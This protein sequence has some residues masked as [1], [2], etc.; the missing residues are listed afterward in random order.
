VSARD[1]YEVLGV[2]KTA[3]EDE[4]RTQ[5]RKLALKYH[6]DKN[7]GDKQAEER[8]KELAQAY[9]VLS[10]P[11]KRRAYDTRGTR[12]GPEPAQGAGGWEGPEI[13]IE[14]IL[15]RYGD[16]FGGFGERFH[17]GRPAQRRGEDALA[18]ITVDFRTAALGGSVA[19]AL[20]GPVA[21]D[22]CGGSG[23]RAG[24]SRD[25]PECGGSGRVSRATG[26][27]GDMFT[28]T[29]ACPRCEGT[30]L[31]PASRCP[32][33]GGAGA[34]EREREVTVRVPEGTADGSTLRLRGMGSAGMRGGP[35]GD[36]LLEVR[37][38]KDPHWR[39][40]GNDVH[41]PLPVPAPL[42]V[43]GG[44]V[45]ARTLRGEG[46]VTIPA[47]TSSGTVLRLKG[48]GILGGDHLAHVELTVP[49]RPTPEQLDLYRRLSQ[50][51]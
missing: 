30:G 33:C 43:V 3:T 19:I 18:A 39:R 28:V 7:P 11:E 24:A 21:C 50:L 47:G 8:F 20:A 6:P 2:A 35:A 4:I 12:R 45:R 26:R 25:C 40:E 37:V 1:P 15:Q 49:P 27:R 36:L 23:T 16:V 48:Q 44:K 13:S 34:V 17:R 41:A 29:S 14:E 32:T 51:E 31:D 9:D 22:T 42:A 10:D 5:Y 38:A 46:D